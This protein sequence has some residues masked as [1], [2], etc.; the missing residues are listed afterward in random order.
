MGQAEALLDNLI[1][2]YQKRR[3]KSGDSPGKKSDE[4]LTQVMKGYFE[5]VRYARE[6]NKPLAWV[7]LFFPSILLEAMDIVPFVAEQYVIQLIGQGIG[8]RYFE[9]GDGYGTSMESC[10]P[11]RAMIGMAISGELP[12]P[13]LILTTSP[14]TCDSSVGTF[15]ILA[16]FFKCPA[17]FLD[18][19]YPYNFNAVPYLKKE[20]EELIAFLEKETGKK[21]NHHK[22]EESLNIAQQTLNYDVQINELRKAIPCPISARGVM[23]LL[24]T[25]L[26]G[27]GRPETLSFAQ[28]LYQETGDRVAQG[29]GVIEGDTI[30]LAW[31]GPLPFFDMKIV[32]WMEKNYGAVIVLDLLNYLPARADFEPP[33]DLLEWL[34]M[35]NLSHPGVRMSGAY[36]EEV[37]VQLKKVFREARLDG[38]I[39]FA[40]FG[41]KQVPGMSRLMIDDIKEAAGIPT[42][43]L[44]GDILDQRIASGNVLR[45][46]LTEYITMIK[47]KSTIGKLS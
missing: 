44:D 31:N 24:W 30:R 4:H 6:R 12:Q 35:L 45:A 46:K 33:S 47:N 28:S 40:H 7:T 39:F 17:Y 26:C 21:L 23:P 22:L 25:R 19:K 11:H 42:F 29:K 2:G 38:S 14:L 37:R 34:A 1:Q 32:N 43:V 3:E 20:L 36:D 8:T 5:R 27:E 41:C 10:S 15:E 16:D 13:D 18:Y 9:V